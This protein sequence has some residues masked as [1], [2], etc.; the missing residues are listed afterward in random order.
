MVKF[1]CTI[2]GYV[3]DESLGIP[4]KSIPPGTKWESLPGDFACPLCSAPKSLFKPL[5]GTSSPAHAADAGSGETSNAE[6]SRE[7]KLLDLSAEEIS[8]ICSNLAKG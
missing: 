8:A 3:Y 2:C 7:K 1:K 6:N 4:E 5:E